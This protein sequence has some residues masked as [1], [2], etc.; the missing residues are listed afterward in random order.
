V[1]PV[2]GDGNHDDNCDQDFGQNEDAQENANES[3]RRRR[4]SGNAQTCDQKLG[5]IIHHLGTPLINPS[6]FQN[7]ASTLASFMVHNMSVE[8][9]HESIKVMIGP[10]SNRKGWNAYH[11]RLD[12]HLTLVSTTAPGS[13]AGRPVTKRTLAAWEQHQP[14]HKRPSSQSQVREGA[15][16]EAQPTQR[17]VLG[18]QPL[19]VVEPETRPFGWCLNFSGRKGQAA[20]EYIGRWGTME[21]WIVEV[22][23]DNKHVDY[24]KGDRWFMTITNGKVQG[25]ENH[26]FI[27]ACRWHKKNSTSELDDKHPANE[28]CEIRQVKRYGPPKCAIFD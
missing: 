27:T 15:P 9:I 3:S 16:S 13:A 21:K 18:L 8:A 5:A 1:K 25:P 19:P 28:Q 10:S 6:A 24:V 26:Q 20:R 12:G 22:Y 4:T 11:D 23:P 2:D 7:L 14:S 17:P